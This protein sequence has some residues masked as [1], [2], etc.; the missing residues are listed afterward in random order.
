[1]MD[2]ASTRAQA[3]EVAPSTSCEGDQTEATMAKPASTPPPLTVDGVD[4][5]YC[6]LAKIHT[7]TATQLAEW[8]HW[9]RSG[10]AASPV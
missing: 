5:M 3:K 10:K 6:K 2:F 7:I 8:A 4:K 9:R 1:M